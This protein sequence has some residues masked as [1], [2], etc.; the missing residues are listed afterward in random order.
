M[1]RQEADGETECRRKG[2]K[3]GGGA[4][5]RRVRRKKTGGAT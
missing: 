2:H 1:D 4:S 5:C 3:E